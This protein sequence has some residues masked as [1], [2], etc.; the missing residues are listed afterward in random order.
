MFLWFVFDRDI[1]TCCSFIRCDFCLPDFFLVTYF[2]GFYQQAVFYQAG[3]FCW[4][5]SYGVSVELLVVLFSIFLFLKL[6]Y[7]CLLSL[8]QHNTYDTALLYTDTTFLISTNIDRTT[9]QTIFQPTKQT[10]LPIC[11]CNI[12]D[13]L[14][15]FT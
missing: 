1:S 5:V 4:I 10:N 14:I 6:E 13:Q 7:I 12:L 9:S 8:P 11:P 15:Y 2:I 3:C